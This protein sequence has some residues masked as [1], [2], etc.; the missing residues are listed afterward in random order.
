MNVSKIM[1]IYKPPQSIFLSYFKTQ[2]LVLAGKKIHG[3]N[4]YNPKLKGADM[5]NNAPIISWKMF[6][7]CLWS[8]L[9]TTKERQKRSTPGRWGMP[10]LR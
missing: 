5:Q 6:G 8:T 7:K 4:A 2:Q 3:V 1:Q 10:L 9:Y